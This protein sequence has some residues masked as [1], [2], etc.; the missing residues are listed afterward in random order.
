MEKTAMPATDLILTDNP[1]IAGRED[2]YSV[3]KID[4]AKVLKSWKTSLFSFEWLNPDG[5]IRKLDDLPMQER[6]KRLEAEIRLK[7]GKPLERPVLG[8]GIMDHIE[9]G[10]G[11]AVFLTLA[12]H[13][14]KVI[15]VHIPSSN[16]SDFKPFLA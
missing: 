5:S 7:S 6:D 9:I 3:I 13:G 14:H 2:R 10:S 15:D 16:R 1:A 11:R 4:T 8:I 12:S